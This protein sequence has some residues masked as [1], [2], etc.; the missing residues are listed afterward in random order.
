M[1]RKMFYAMLLSTIGGIFCGI[2]F[3]E[4][5]LSIGW[6]DV[7]FINLLKL[8]AIPLIFCTIVSAIIS[9]G[10]VK[11]LK[12]I[13]V[14]TLLYVLISASIAV[15]IGLLLSN[16][17]KPGNGMSTALIHLNATPDKFK[18]M[19]ISSYFL[20]YLATLFPKGLINIDDES[21]YIMPL[22]LFSV[23]FAM[24]CVSIGESAKPISAL[25]VA[26]RNVLNRI[27]LWSMYFSPVGLFVILGFSIAEGYTKG[28]LLQNIEG[29]FYFIGVLFIGLLC[30]FLWQFAVIKYITRRNPKEFL[31]N[32]TGAMLIAFATASSLTALPYTL[33][34]AKE[35]KINEEI[36]DFVLPFAT[37]INLA[38]TAMYEA[39]A[40]LFFCQILGIQLS[41]FS[42]IGIFLT[43][44]LAG[45]GAGGI[46]EGGMITMVM[47]LRSASVPTSAMALLLPF[48]RL[49]DRFRTVVNVWGD[50]VCA[51]TVNHFVDR[52]GDLSPAS[53]IEP[54]VQNAFHEQTP[55]AIPMLTRE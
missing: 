6:I 29:L 55:V 39:V 30:Q 27:I 51:M 46:P 14:Y 34:A 40:T 1:P 48:D 5:M 28:I 42:Q 21:F 23:V 10:N 35:E 38:G 41:I 17:F 3:P 18:T 22:V 54:E 7:L 44:I 53:E 4:Q 13:W 19:S 9:M 49:L 36:A 33:L 43:S 24:A 2:F 26:F 32:A 31:K 8:I 15:L 37:T 47:V 25:F 12:S 16:F 50:L 11:R 45:I 52:S 20:T